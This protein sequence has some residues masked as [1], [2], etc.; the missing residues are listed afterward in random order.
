M[1]GLLWDGVLYTSLLLFLVVFCQR[2]KSSNRGLFLADKR[3]VE[4]NLLVV[5]L[6]V[7]AVGKQ[8]YPVV[9]DYL[10]LLLAKTEWW[11]QVIGNQ[12]NKAEDFFQ[13]REFSLVKVWASTWAE[14]LALPRSFQVCWLSKNCLKLQSSS[15]PPHLQDFLFQNAIVQLKE[16]R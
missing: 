11:T 15:L 9:T 6:L 12:R 2:Q 4:P 10:S 8:N 1:Q 3:Q 7:A 13:L 5:W 16:L 14:F